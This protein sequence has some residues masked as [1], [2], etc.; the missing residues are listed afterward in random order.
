MEIRNCFR[1]VIEK[2]NT[3]DA[4]RRGVLFIP[5]GWELTLGGM[6]RPQSLINREI[7]ECDAFFLVLHDRWGSNPGAPEGYTS[8]TEEEYHKALELLADPG[9]DM[10]DI[11]VFFKTVEPARLSDPGEQLRSVLDFKKVLE[12]E[13]KL[14]F[15]QFDDIAEFEGALRMFLA[16]WVRRHEDN[17]LESEAGAGG[18]RVL[19]A[20][21]KETQSGFEGVEGAVETTRLAEDS[22]ED[23]P[24]EKGSPLANAAALAAEGRLTEAETMY[25]QLT[26]ANNDPAA[27]FA[28]GEFLF[29]LGRKL[30]AE[31]FLRRAIE[32]A[33]VAGE[34]QWVAQSQAALGRLLA[35]KGDYDQ[36]TK[37]LA[38]AERLYTGMQSPRELA[39]VRLHLGEILLHREEFGAATEKYEQALDALAKEYDPEIGADIHAA[40]GQLNRDTGDLDAS[41]KNYKAAIE[42]KEEIGST[43]DLADFYAGYGAVLEDR[44]DLEAAR[45]AYRKSLELFEASGNY[46]GVADISDHLGHVFYGLGKM[47]EAEAAFD[48]SAGVFETVQN[49]DGAV[50]AYTSLG[51]LQTELGRMQEATSSFRQALAL[52]GRIKNKEEVTEIYES[53][54]R[55]IGADDEGDLSRGSGEVGMP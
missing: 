50:D 55:L 30:Q 2:Y 54:G 35:S 25:A 8:G 45:D 18:L 47:E 19:K 23:R 32:I 42:K 43:K 28:Y 29:R 48:R 22:G 12:Q 51:K 1:M 6:G 36:G 17:E 52:V 27:A 31:E 16:S 20:P 9:K 40:L 14:L 11:S 13:K 39:S 38:E 37:A 24:P 15:Q 34:E 26:A 5:V 4:I 49:F 44:G 53:L 21:D 3:E 46:S 41:A 33:Q 10:R 7:E